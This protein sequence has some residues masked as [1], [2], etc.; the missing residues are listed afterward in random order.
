MRPCSIPSGVRR[1]GFCARAKPCASPRSTLPRLPS[2]ACSSDAPFVWRYY[3]K[4]PSPMC[5]L[6]CQYLPPPA[7][8]P[9]PYTPVHTRGAP[10]PFHLPAPVWYHP[11]SPIPMLAS[12]PFL[13]FVLRPSVRAVPARH[14]STRLD[15]CAVPVQSLRAL[16]PAHTVRR[17]QLL[18]PSRP[19]HPS[20]AYR[21][22]NPRTRH[23]SVI[24]PARPVRRPSLPPTA[25]TPQGD[26][27]A[28]MG[29]D[30]G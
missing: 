9:I 13:R 2:F 3:S 15:L 4:P 19:S 5:A 30:C 6:S 16:C 8:C 28:G 20:R 10:Y 12:A 18:D 17:S 24:L 27:C 29:D 21:H 11:K 7:P 22:G 26:D 23:P 25:R 14:L 1:A